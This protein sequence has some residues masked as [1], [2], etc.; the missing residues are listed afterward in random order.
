MSISG[1]PAATSEPKASTRMPIVT[2]Q[3][4]T[5]DLS[6]A[7]LLAWLK[8]DHMP[9]A[10]VRFTLTPGE[11]SLASLPLSESAARTISFELR[12]APAW[13]TAVWP[14][15][16]IAAGAAADRAH[17]GAGRQRSLGGGERAPEAGS[18]RLSEECTTTIRP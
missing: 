2:G 18:L 14:S 17:G 4:M 3:E 16:E 11:P 10:P 5:S 15:R 13:I 7:D 8:S 9:D 12:A 6:I 1:S